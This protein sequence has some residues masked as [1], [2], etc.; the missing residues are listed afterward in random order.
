MR[1]AG[2]W[3]VF[4]LLISYLMSCAVLPKIWNKMRDTDPEYELAMKNADT[5]KVCDILD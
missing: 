1:S 2:W 5:A 3:I 4:L